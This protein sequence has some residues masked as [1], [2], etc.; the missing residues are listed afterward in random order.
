MLNAIILEDEE[1][2]R[3]LLCNLLSDYCPEVK[4]LAAV[5][6]VKAAM[7]AINALNPDL[8][9]MDIELIGETSFELLEKLHDIT[10]EIIFITAH[11]KYILRA[12]KLSA[13]DYI[14]K[15]VDVNELKM[16]IEKVAKM[17][18]RRMLNDNLEVLMNNLKNNYKDHYISIPSAI[19]FDRVKVSS[20]IYLESDGAY[21]HFLL[22]TGQKLTASKNIREYEEI[23]EG[24][25]FFRIHKSHII[26]LAEISRYIKGEGGQVVMNNDATLDV[27]RRRKDDFLKLL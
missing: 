21:T 3:K 18:T 19:G 15:P 25:N 9:L 24:H 1:N 20:I 17:R 22:K 13:V 27:S 11:D 5:D 10:F 26:N 8:V 6:S 14:L 7:S 2:S 23:L 16:A 12:I 4:L